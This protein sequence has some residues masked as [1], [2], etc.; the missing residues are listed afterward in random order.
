MIVGGDIY[1]PKRINPTGFSGA[2]IF[3]YTV[4]L[5]CFSK[6]S[7]SSPTTDIS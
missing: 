7:D 6:I 3:T 2:R 1:G 5:Q 4:C